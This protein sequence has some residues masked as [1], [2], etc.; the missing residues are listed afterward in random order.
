MNNLEDI[1]TKGKL[2]M[3]CAGDERELKFE[4]T[5]A[6][7]ELDKLSL[8]KS[9]SFSEKHKAVADLMEYCVER[10]RELLGY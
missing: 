4:F 1:V 2:E 7:M 10:N 9:M 6:V 3:D 5:S 8:G